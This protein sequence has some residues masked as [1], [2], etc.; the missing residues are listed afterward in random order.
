MTDPRLPR[1]SVPAMLRERAAA[2][3]EA[4]AFC[5]E[6][7]DGSWIPMAW[8][9]FEAETR[10]L[11]AGLLRHG[12]AKGDR[13]ALIAPVSLEWELLHHAA[14][15]IGAV[16]VGL[17]AHDLP[18]RVAAMCETA[19]ITAVA[20]THAGILSALKPER[21]RRLGFVVLLPVSG[22]SS[23]SSGLAAPAFPAL[24]LG[25][26]KQMDGG[27][28][29]DRAAPPPAPDDTA[30]IIFTSGTT[31]DPK[32]IAYTH[33]QVCLAIDAISDAFPFVGP[34]S[35]L[36][37]WLPLSNLFQRM[38]NLAG[39][40]RGATSYLLADPRRVMD[41]VA[42]V[43]PD[44]FIGVPRFYEKLYQ[45]IQARIGSLAA[46]QRALTRL[47]CTVARR[48][49][50]SQPSTKPTSPGMVLALAHRILDRTV[51]RRVRATMGT[52]LRC[53]VTG[54]APTPEYLLH[55]F[56]AIGWLLLES[57][58]LSENVLPMA[59]NRVDDFC[60]GTV[61]KPL[62]ANTISIGAG[63]EIM[64]RGP[65]VFS[66]YLGAD[67]QPAQRTPG[68]HLTGDLGSIDES[69]NLRLIGRGDDIVKTSTGQKIS[70]PAVEA[71]LRSVEEIDEAVVLAAGRKYPIAICTIKE[72]VSFAERRSDLDTR[73]N[74][75]LKDIHENVRPRLV[76][77]SSDPF[78]ISS[79]QITTNLKLRRQKIESDFL[80]TIDHLSSISTKAD[81]AQSTAR[82]FWVAQS[83]QSQRQV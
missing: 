63:G 34:G 39:M 11:A 66:G 81:I 22:G 82:I 57:Y 37:C 20:T 32:G 56:R 78:S 61:G 52:R 15:S 58:G 68:D 43:S 77:L 41:V 45:G 36:L 64:V 53:M 26:L 4:T 49:T 40:R 16:V 14:L 83:D 10:R 50:T 73:M 31:G 62:T 5:S 80:D 38:V 51:L 59:M 35:H 18:A 48:A 23:G 17:D 65:G 30:T 74:E 44:V 46:P 12:L 7:A 79:G 76:L 55:E 6:R 75:V 1:T 9:E 21:Q 8:R 69:G 13:L 19:D 67:G 42:Q 47:A 70:L 54:S 27:A 28:P 72:G 60:F 25:Q 29:T 3:P 24:T 2:S 71:I 33:A